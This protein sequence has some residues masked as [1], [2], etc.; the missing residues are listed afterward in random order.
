MGEKNKIQEDINMYE[1]YYV[2]FIKHNDS[3][4]PYV[5]ELHYKP[6]VPSRKTNESKYYQFKN[7]FKKEDYIKDS[8]DSNNEKITSVFSIKF[9]EE[10]KYEIMDVFE[11][12]TG[13]TYKDLWD[14]KYTRFLVYDNAKAFIDSVY[15]LETVKIFFD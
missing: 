13:K 9:K 14:S 3:E 5:M 4:Y 6:Y 12:I 10:D 1:G 15:K 8:N 7:E 11:K 2:A